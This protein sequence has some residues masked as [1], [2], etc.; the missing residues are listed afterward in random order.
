MTAAPE[1]DKAPAEAQEYGLPPGFV[2][3]IEEALDDHRLAEVEERLAPLHS[4]DLAALLEA[5]HP[6]DRRVVVGLIRVQ[7]TTDAE[8]LAWLN[9]DVRQEVLDLLGPQDVAA[10]LQELD[11]DD[12][13]AL[14]ETLDEGGRDAVLANIPA[15]ERRLLLEG[16]DF[17]EYS[18]GRLMQRELV[19]VP[20]YWTVGKTIDWLRT[21]EDLPDEFYS[22][23][24]VDAHGLPTGQLPL[25]RFL[26]G[27]RPAK[28]AELG[29]EDIHP[30]P[31]EMDQEE[32]ALLFRRY[33]MVS[34]PV[35]DRN[36]KLLG[37]ITLDDVVDVIDEEA[38]EDIFRL[39]GIGEQSDLYRDVAATTRSRFSWLFVNLLTAVL[40]SSVIGLFEDTISKV[41]A[42][43]VLMPIVASMG[44]NAGTQTLTVAVRALAMRELTDSNAVRI[45]WKEVLVGTINGLLFAAIAGG[46]V[47]LWFADPRLAVVIGAAMIIN[48]LAAAFSGTVIPLAL[49]RFGVDP[50]V[51]SGVFLTTVTDVVGFFAFLGLAALILL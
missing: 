16:L 37:V 42:L 6:D 21:A 20:D 24:L 19:A 3:E 17:P 38:E 13:L 36:G 12:A 31:A 43:A 49:Q 10:A 44:G 9:E 7:L 15:E 33:G 22:L 8:A 51:S 27:R 32:V 2:Q 41:V 26:R 35:V 4:A 39:G 45:L 5:L 47:W 25:S 11:S 23:F 46:V 48:L 40:A 18:A 28:L 50:A 34:A 1:G 30:I 29:L 14:I